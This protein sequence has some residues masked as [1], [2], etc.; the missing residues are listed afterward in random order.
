MKTYENVIVDFL[1]EKFGSSIADQ[2]IEKELEKKGLK[3]IKEL[4]IKSQVSFF[5]NFLRKR[6]ENFLS[7]EEI[8]SR[9]MQL[10]LQ[11]CSLKASEKIS[12]ELN[13]KITFEPFEIKIQ[14]PGKA[15]T[16]INSLLTNSINIS[17]TI[18]GDISAET[19]FFFN[20]EHAI[21]ISEKIAPAFERNPKEGEVDKVSIK[22]FLELLLPKILES[23][24]DLLENSYSYKFLEVEEIKSENIISNDKSETV[25]FSEVPLLLNNEKYYFNFMMILKK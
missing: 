19:I 15:I 18:S 23:A 21:K 16:T 4:G 1:K 25:L 9:I 7:K 3:S 24:S 5:E 22:K 14:S 8:E 6:Y 11:Y 17:V 12:K 2:L 13:K 10:N 20:K